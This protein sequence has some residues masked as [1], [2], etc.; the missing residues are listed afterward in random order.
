RACSSGS[1]HHVASALLNKTT[2]I[3]ML[4]VLGVALAGRR[5]LASRA[6]AIR[7]LTTLASMAVPLLA[8]QSLYWIAGEPSGPT[9]KAMAL[10]WTPKGLDELWPHPIFGL[11]FVT[12]FL[13]GLLATFWRGD[14]VWHLAPV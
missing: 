8:W 6:E 7:A 13:R 11:P 9:Q 14:L 1:G 3:A 5:P 12:V 4:L 10:G 2:A